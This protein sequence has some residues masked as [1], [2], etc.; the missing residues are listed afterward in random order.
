MLLLEAIIGLIA[1]IVSGLFSSGGGMIIV[2]SLIY[3]FKLDQIKARATSV[4][5]IFPMVIVT[6]IIYYSKNFLDWK[7]GMLCAIRWNI[8]WIHWSKSFK[9]NV[10]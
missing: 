5:V 9:K 4:F 2:P 10:R 1:G 8:W 7:I 3:I 6:G